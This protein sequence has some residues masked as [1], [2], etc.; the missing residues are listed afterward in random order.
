MNVTDSFGVLFPFWDVA[1]TIKTALNN[2]MSSAIDDVIYRR[3]QYSNRSWKQ[4]HHNLKMHILVHPKHY[5]QT[6]LSSY[7]RLE[8]R[9]TNLFNFDNT[10]FKYL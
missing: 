4:R 6:L 2:E 1:F 9:L 3:M 7:Q 8:H 5:L 10:F